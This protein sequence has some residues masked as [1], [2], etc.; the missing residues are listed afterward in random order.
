MGMN[1]RGTTMHKQFGLNPIH[2][3]ILRT[4]VLR[5]LRHAILTGAVRPGERLIE[6]ALARE[7]AVSRGTVREVIRQLEQ[8]GL[9]ESFPHR[10]SFVTVV[11]EVEIHAI[12]ELRAHLEA[13][14]VRSALA[15]GLGNL[16]PKLVELIPEMEKAIQ[17]GDQLQVTELDVHFHEL[18]VGHCGYTSWSRIWRT[19]DGLVRRYIYSVNRT[20][21]GFLA[22]TAESHRPILAALEAGDADRAEAA[23]RHH[24]LEP[25][26][27]ARTTAPEG[28]D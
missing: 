20:A 1:E 3:N 15:S 23:V 16:L 24:I 4:D 11:S 26:P 28:Q 13:K 17:A 9:V 5:A 19:I 12:M 2:P 25:L 18:I 21:P 22:A 7:L 8:E 6:E 27:W 14:A 10:G